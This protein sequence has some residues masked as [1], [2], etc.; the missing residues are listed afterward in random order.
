LVEREHTSNAPVGTARVTIPAVRYTSREFVEAE[1][2]HLWCNT[3][4]FAG[5][6]SDVASAG[7][8]FVFEL[9]DESVL[10][11]RGP[12]GVNAFH[13]VCMH[14]GHILCEARGHRASF[15]CPYHSW[16]WSLDGRLAH[17]PLAGEFPAGIPREFRHLQPV[18]CRVWAGLVWI[19]LNEP[20]EPLDQYLGALAVTIAAADLSSLAL[21]EDSTF[22]RSANWK[23]AAEAWATAGSYLFPNV[24]LTLA[25]GDVELLRA[26][27]DAD[28]PRR[29]WL[30]VFRLTRKSTSHSRPE[31]VQLSPRDA[32]PWPAAGPPDPDARAALH[33]R[34]D[35]YLADH[36]PADARL[37]SG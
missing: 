25:G 15:V 22:Q 16:T 12:D 35:T 3:W 4:L 31:H 36:I 11:V 17:V 5:F 33:G 30:D 8:Y 21:V 18:T 27:P 9:G 19:C 29:A 14:R 6:A 2:S 24:L 37:I 26:R 28:D 10:I 1:R 34:I 13:N 23:T 32:G 7:D 20:R